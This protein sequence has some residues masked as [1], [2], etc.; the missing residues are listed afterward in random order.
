MVKP[1]LLFVSQATEA[2]TV[3][4]RSEL[5]G[6]R[7]VCDEF[8][9]L[10]Y[11]DGARL[12]NAL[13]SEGCDLSLESLAGFAD[14]FYIGGTKNGLLFGEALVIVN[15]SLK[16]DFRFLMKQRG[17]LLAKGFL[18][19]LQFQ[20]L[21]GDGLWLELARYANGMAKRLKKGLRKKGVTLFA[22]NKTNQVFLYAPPDMMPILEE[23]VLFEQ[24]GPETPD[25]VP[26]R[27][28][29]SWATTIQEINS[30]LELF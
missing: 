11:I 26:I 8:G 14:A 22:E 9:L 30:A 1:R 17:A 18:L 13:V 5:A 10:L 7:E 19:G 20:A 27:F 23:R 16:E 6:L 12:A 15:P 21:L 4:T 25:G 2:G 29:T 24:W 28:V 3:Y